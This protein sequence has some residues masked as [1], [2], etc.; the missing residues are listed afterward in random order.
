M[1]KKHIFPLIHNGVKIVIILF[2][3]LAVLIFP[4]EISNGV[5]N[6]LILLGENLI[7][8]LFPFMVLSAYITASPATTA[9]SK[10]L[11]RPSRF[12]FRTNGVGV[13]CFLLS[14]LGGY[15][16]GAKT[17]CEYYSDKKLSEK[18]CHKLLCWC[19]NPSPAFTITAIGRFMLGNAL[20]GGI[21]FFSVILASL[22]M[23]FLAGRLHKS[24][25]EIHITSQ[26][27]PPEDS[28][29]RAVSSG[30]KAMLSICGW[31]LVFS[32]LCGGLNAI[33]KQSYGLLFIKSI[34]EITTGLEAL[35]TE[36]FPLP[37]LAA[38]S[39]FGGFAV[40]FQ[41]APYLEKC[42][43]PLK[44]FLCIRVINSALSAFYCSF[45]TH[46]FPLATQTSQ[47]ISMGTSQITFSYNTT[48]SVIL[49]LTCILLI[50]EVDKKR[51]LC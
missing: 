51:K 20:C 25:D 32:A 4:K 45:L 19:T 48:A 26:T 5:K 50:L 29:V 21:I 23:G 14:V 39:G 43:F 41:I 44:T 16:I 42:K 36:G 35:S 8:A 46:F 10:K 15:P 1:Y 22:T 30:S 13:I 49:F 18:E 31:V 33:L 17:I 34:A 7:P 28:F 38:A 11:N 2:C 27:P 47:T 37:V 6:G 40:I 9:L 24:S 3:V 12:L